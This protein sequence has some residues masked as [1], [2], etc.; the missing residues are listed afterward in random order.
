M[1][2]TEQRLVEAFSHI[3]LLERRMIELENKAAKLKGAR[4]T[5][6]KE[7]RIAREEV[8]KSRARMDNLKNSFQAFWSKYM[9]FVFL[10]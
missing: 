7:L 4:D 8:K 5:L 2:M 10:I 9:E 3:D 6:R 1:E